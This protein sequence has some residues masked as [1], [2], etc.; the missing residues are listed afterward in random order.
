MA[1]YY[2]VD[3]PHI[4]PILA[5]WFYQQWPALFLDE[6]D[7]IRDLEQGGYRDRIPL[8]LVEMENDKILGTA[9][10]L[11]NDMNEVYPHTSPWLACVYV[12][13]IYRGQGIG[14]KMVQA[15]IKEARR[16]SFKKLYLW[17]DSQKTFYEAMGWKPIKEMIY[18]TY[19]VT[20]MSIHLT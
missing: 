18:K 8:Y 10:I 1:L 12:P 4:I 9:A 5:H 6:T 2:L 11:E 13:E 14:K 17:T 3:V 15:A 19:P 16:L 7:A 20:V